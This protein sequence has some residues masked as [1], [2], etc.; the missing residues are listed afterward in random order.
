MKDNKISYEQ[1]LIN[2]L[3]IDY[4]PGAKTKEELVLFFGIHKFSDMY[5]KDVLDSLFFNDSEKQR[6]DGYYLW[7]ENMITH[8]WYTM[9]YSKGMSYPLLTALIDSMLAEKETLDECI[10]ELDRLYYNDSRGI[11][12]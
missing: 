8:E 3:C 1:A 5:S 12:E 7:C 2:R 10:D 4:N 11:D 9:P 6:L